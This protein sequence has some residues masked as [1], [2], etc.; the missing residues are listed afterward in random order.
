MRVIAIPV[1]KQI[2]IF[3]KIKSPPQSLDEDNCRNKRSC[4][5]LPL[6]SHRAIGL[7]RTAHAAHDHSNWYVCSSR[8][9]DFSILRNTITKFNKN[10]ITIFHHKRKSGQTLKKFDPDSYNKFIKSL[11]ATI[12]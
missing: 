11:W 7:R 2:E 4:R 3:P 10:D 5:R 6:S 8:S 12:L 1:P 9:T